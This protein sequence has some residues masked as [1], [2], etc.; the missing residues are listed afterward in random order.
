MSYIPP[1]V[2]SSLSLLDPAIT[3]IL[4][5]VI[6]VEDWPSVFSWL[7]G[8]LVVGGVAV[9]SSHHNTSSDSD[10]NSDVEGED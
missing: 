9:I 4:S 6:G 8:G 1:L 2:F 7:G 3:A 5:Y 10:S